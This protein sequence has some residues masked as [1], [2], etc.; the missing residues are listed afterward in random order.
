LITPL[1]R[2]TKDFD[3]DRSFTS[4]LLDAYELLLLEAMEGDRTLFLREDGV[5]RAWEVVEP[6]L[7]EPP[8]LVPYD[9]GSWGPKEADELIAPR[10]WHVSGDIG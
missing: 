8:P 3:Y 7:K 9:E 6:L 4:E 1:G 10:R 2:A 5:E